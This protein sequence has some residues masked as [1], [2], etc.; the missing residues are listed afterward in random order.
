MEVLSVLPRTVLPQG[1]ERQYAYR[2]TPNTA[3]TF[4]AKRYKF[5]F[6]LD[7]SPSVATVDQACSQVLHD[8]IF[9]SLRTAIQGLVKPVSIVYSL[10]TAILG[11]GKPVSE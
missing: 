5:V 1:E 2:I 10:H 3:A 6:V 9:S 11:P 7:I 4:L 8:E